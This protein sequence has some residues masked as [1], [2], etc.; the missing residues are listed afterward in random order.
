MDLIEFN[1]QFSKIDVGS[2]SSSELSLI[3]AAGIDLEVV[4]DIL[5]LIDSSRE[6]SEY[7]RDHE[8]IAKAILYQNLTLKKGKFVL[9][10]IY[11]GEYIA[12]IASFAPELNKF[13]IH[14]YYFSD[15]NHGDYFVLVGDFWSEILAIYH[16]SSGLILQS[17]ESAKDLE[18][19]VSILNS[20]L[21][22]NSKR[23]KGYTRAPN[24]NMVMILYHT[25]FAH[26]V[27]NELSAI[28]HIIDRNGLHSIKKIYI[29]SEPVSKVEDLFPELTN[30]KIELIRMPYYKA[31]NSVYKNRELILSNRN[32]RIQ[33]DLVIR[34]LSDAKSHL[35]SS[36][37]SFDNWNQQ[38]ISNSFKVWLTIRVGGRT[39][40]DIVNG[41]INV[42]NEI[43]KTNSKLLV[44]FDGFS[45]PRFSDKFK[46]EKYTE[47]LQKEN[48]V[49]NKILRGVKNPIE[50]VNLIGKSTD[51]SFIWASIMDLYISHH[52]TIQHKVAWFSSCPG[53]VHTNSIISA[54]PSKSRQG[55]HD[56]VSGFVPHYLDPDVVTTFN[57]KV[58]IRTGQSRGGEHSDYNFDWR[59][60][61]K[62]IEKNKLLSIKQKESLFSEPKT[63][64]QRLV[65]ICEKLRK[66]D[67]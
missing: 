23:L 52:G 49:V 10:S 27:L 26:H 12:A 64:L 55:S 31:L 44:V 28:Q 19:Y 9:K 41:Y 59:E 2:I 30:H 15:P 60:I 40:S 37:Y 67:S 1:D 56:R 42:I 7:R 16:P 54:K 34:I 24:K 3:L 45:F 48:A 11:T 21:E 38:R 36:D 63:V 18:E 58:V 46:N 51:L 25:H 39:W 4:R 35:L 5:F 13:H 14:A 47:L 43:Q 32:C 53:I 50:H 61:M 62:I 65:Q 22:R 33:D 29:S 66:N 20:H 8:R 57:N 6:W 17:F